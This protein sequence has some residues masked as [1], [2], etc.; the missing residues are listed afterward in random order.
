MAGL[1]CVSFM[2]ASGTLACSGGCAFNFASCVPMAAT[3]GDGVVAGSEQCDSGGS[4]AG[5][6]SCVVQMG[7]YCS[8]SP[9]TCMTVCGDSVMAGTEACDPPI[10]GA[11]S[12]QCGAGCVVVL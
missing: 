1:S 11:I 5:C 12:G 4:T 6:M 9:S 3:C 7:Y 10:A 2:Y 8:G